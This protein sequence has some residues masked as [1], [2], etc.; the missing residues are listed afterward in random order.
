MSQLHYPGDC[1]NF[2]PDHIMGPDMYEG[3]WLPVSATYDPGTDLTTMT[4]RPVPPAELKERR[5]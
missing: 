1:T 5:S 2:D 4:L 3:H